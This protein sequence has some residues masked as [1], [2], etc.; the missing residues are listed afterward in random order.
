MAGVLDPIDQTEA[1]LDAVQKHPD[2][3]RIYA[4]LTMMRARSES[5]A[6]HD[7]AK[8]ERRHSL[9]DGVAVSWKDNIDS[10]GTVTEAGSKLLEGR[11]PRKDAIVLARAARQGTVCLGKTHMTELAFSGLGLNPRTAT[12]PN[13]LDPALAPGGSSSGAAVSVALGLAAAA[14]GSDTGGSVRVPAA[15]N[16][17]VGFKPTHG[18]LPEKGVVP[19]CRRFDVVGPIARTVEDC[20]ELLA[21]M[22]AERPADLDGA[23]INGACLMVLDGLPFDAVEEG[24]ALAFQDGVDRLACAGARIHHVSTDWLDRAMALSAQVFAPEAYGIWRAQIEDAPELMWPPILERFRGGAEVSAPDYV[25]AWEQLSRIR[26][27]W[28]KEVASR[29]DS[30]LLPT[31]PIMP[32]DAQRLMTDNDAFVHANLLTLRNTRIAN[33]LGLPAVTLPTGHP[34][35]G[36]MMMGHAGRDRQLLRSAAAAEAALGVR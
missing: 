14:I 2:G 36:L 21:L 24:P 11:I 6:A 3:K 20:A 15:W 19:L 23:S 4:R 12:P 8:A 9:L 5:I 7:R 29:F 10:G 34:G 25:A 33:L 13:A 27:K 22:A 31:V 1:Y 16:G 17:L 30:V 32:P 35:C 28:I 26:R 18:G